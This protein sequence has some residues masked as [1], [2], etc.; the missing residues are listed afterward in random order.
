VT[1]RGAV[2]AV[3]GLHG[4]AGTTTTALLLAAHAASRATEG[5]VVVTETAPWGGGLAAAPLITDAAWRAVISPAPAGQDAKAC[6]ARLRELANA[7]ALLVVD[8][9]SVREARARIA[10]EEADAGVVW[11]AAEHRL[12]RLAGAPLMADLAD[13]AERARRQI[14]A[15][16]AA[17][18]AV[19]PAASPAT[20][21]KPPVRPHATV[22][23]PRLDG[24]TPSDER[25]RLASAA[26]ARAL[27]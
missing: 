18:P 27:V 22:L 6:M 17:D 20:L 4:G 13:P 21:P 14:L 12:A 8:A 16:S 11:T 1:A 15:I 24:A 7:H 9:G 3:C 26:L 23:L 19:P 5:A 25:Y 10:L 2:I